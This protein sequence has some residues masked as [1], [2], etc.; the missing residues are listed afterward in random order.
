[1]R[2][3][4]VAVVFG[5]LLVAV[6]TRLAEAAGTRQCGCHGDC[7]CKKPG[8]SLFRWVVPGRAHRRWTAEEKRAFEAALSE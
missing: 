8:L 7:W 6:A 5:V 2:R 1:M 3:I 4:A